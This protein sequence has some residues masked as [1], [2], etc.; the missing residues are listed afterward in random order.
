MYRCDECLEMFEEP[1][2]HETTWESYYGVA[3]EFSNGTYL[4]LEL[5][6]YCGSDVIEEIEKEEE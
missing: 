3:S 2:I 5:C 4:R 6:P 1:I